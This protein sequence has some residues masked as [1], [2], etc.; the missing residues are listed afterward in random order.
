ER[1]VVPAAIRLRVPSLPDPFPAILADEAPGT[2]TALVRGATPGFATP[3][4]RSP[5]FYS[6]GFAHRRARSAVA[7]PGERGGVGLTRQPAQ[8]SAFQVIEKAVPP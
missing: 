2:R 8:L 7:G 4:F 5:V 3:V 1:S 6:T